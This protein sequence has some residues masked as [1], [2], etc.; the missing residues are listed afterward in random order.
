VEQDPSLPS[1]STILRGCRIY[2]LDGELALCWMPH[3]IDEC[4]RGVP[5]HKPLEPQLRVWDEEL[6]RVYPAHD[7]RKNDGRHPSDGY[8]RAQIAYLDSKGLGHGANHFGHWHARGQQSNQTSKSN[9]PWCHIL[10]EDTRG[11]PQTIPE[12]VREVH[13]A[14][15]KKYQL[16]LILVEEAL[17]KFYKVLSPEKFAK[18]REQREFIVAEF[19]KYGLESLPQLSENQCHLFMARVKNKSVTNH[20]DEGDFGLAVET[21]FGDFAGGD[22][23]C[24]EL[25]ERF[26]FRAGDFLVMDAKVL[27]H[28]V[29]HFDGERTTI[30]FTSKSS[31]ESRKPHVNYMDDGPEKDAILAEKAAK[32]ATAAGADGIEQQLELELIQGYFDGKARIEEGVLVVD[33]PQ[34]PSTEEDYK[35]I[36]IHLDAKRLEK[37]KGLK[38]KAYK[39]SESEAAEEIAVTPASL[40]YQFASRES[41]RFEKGLN[42]FLSLG[43]QK[44]ENDA[45]E[46]KGQAKGGLKRKRS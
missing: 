22:F 28:C 11:G 44:K 10:S 16:R 3:A 25:N 4:Y 24:S 42:T 29:A 18:S 13:K 15:F 33:K 19:T 1:R 41:K 14:A 38:K 20:K 12:K 35:L 43:E 8:H 6:E 27:A 45:W 23:C 37:A 17:G 36:Y 2:F 31:S 26:Y 46:E 7:P 39:A 9:G 32:D 40:Y 34:F 30:V 5:D 21:T